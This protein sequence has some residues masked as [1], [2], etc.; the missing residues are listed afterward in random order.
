MAI[1]RY[2]K[3]TCAPSPV[4]SGELDLMKK[5]VLFGEDDVAALRQSAA[6][7]AG[8]EEDILNVWYGFVGSNPHL[9][10]SFRSKSTGEPSGEYLAAVRGRFGQW[11]RD[12]AAANYDDAWL[13]YQHEIGRRH[14]R[15]GKNRTDGVDATDHIEWRHLPLLIFPIT[16]TLIPFLGKTGASPEA[17]DRMY[18]AWLKSVLL[19]V[20]LWSHV[21]IR[22]GDF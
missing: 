21:Y 22:E 4:T 7:L 8:Q 5:S 16:Y 15:T 1:K 3:G 6:I 14:H 20:T 11:I 18:R 12:T 19:Q 9:L 13:A 10:N 2:A 17:V